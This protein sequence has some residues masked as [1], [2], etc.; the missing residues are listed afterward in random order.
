MNTKKRF[1]CITLAVMISISCSIFTG[2]LETSVGEIK[3]VNSYVEGSEIFPGCSNLP[4]ER[5]YGVCFIEYAPDNPE[6]LSKPDSD[7]LVAAPGEIT[8]YELPLGSYKLQEWHADVEINQG[9]GYTP[10]FKM[11]LRPPETIE[12]PSDTEIIFG[13]ERSMTASGEFL[14]GVPFNSS[15]KFSGISINLPDAPTGIQVETPS[16]AEVQIEPPDTTV[17]PIEQPNPTQVEY[18]RSFEGV[19]ETNWGEMTCRVDG[20]MVHCDY[21][22]DQGRIDALLSADGKTMEGQ[23]AESPSYSP[24][25][26]GGRV[27]FS[28]SPDGNSIDGYWWYGHNKDGGAWTGVRK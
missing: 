9:P 13:S 4:L 16:Q 26:D 27:T 17:A 24:P 1:M 12:I 10:C 2:I 28:L 5:K 8:S 3:I 7:M 20:V 21:E 23:W 6:E 18:V 11:F 14:E 15:C 22:W 19:W 25:E